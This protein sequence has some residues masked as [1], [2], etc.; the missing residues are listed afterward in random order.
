MGILRNALIIG[1]LA[2][3]V[4][5]P[6]TEKAG[7]IVQPSAFTYV[8]AAAETFA[9]VRAFCDRQPNVCVTA[10]VIANSM[11]AKAKYSAKLIYE[12]ANDATESTPSKLH[13]ADD[14]AAADPIATSSTSGQGSS[15]RKDHVAD[16]SQ[17][18]LTLEDLLPEWQP[19]KAPKKG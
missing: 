12:W 5:T 9:D 19:P 8:T 17:S 16:V 15:K 14:M 11:E 6:P 4:P 7:D 10:G 13:I 1:A 2:M 18:T 3:A